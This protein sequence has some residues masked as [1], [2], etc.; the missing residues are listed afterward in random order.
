MKFLILTQYFHPEIGAAQVRLAA[1]AKELKQLGHDVEIVTAMPNYPQGHIFSTYQ[2]RFY[3]QEQWEGITI[4]RVWLY[5]ATG[6]GIKRLLN[7]LSF[8]LTAFWGLKKAR[9]PDYLFVESPPLFLGITGYLAAKWWKIPFIFNVADLWPDSVSALGLMKQGFILRQFER[10]ERWLY[11]K[12]TYVNV[13]AEGARQIMLDVKKVPTHKVLFLPNGADTA[14]F[15][16]YS[17]DPVLYQRFNLPQKP[18]ILYAG[19]HG[20]AHGMEVI[21]QAAK[22]VA[23]LELLFLFVGGGSDKPRIQQLA[24]EMQL[25]NVKFLPPQSPETVAKL[26]GLSIAGI[27]SFRNVELLDNTRAAKN[28]AV[29]A[30]GKPLIY[31]GGGEGARLI[32]DNQTGLVTPP[33]DANTLAS[34][35]KTIIKQPDYAKKLGRNGRHFIE[36]Q[37][38]W[39]QIITNWL[40]SLIKK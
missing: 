30:C 35:I 33:E 18:I 15:K 40:S 39:H 17:P 38:T 22:L 26:Y 27:S 11:R 10:L 1:I 37:L 2:N 28:L 23:D 20:Y 7:Y 3:L 8:M 13:V 4:H 16:P 21:L 6:A 36:T 34:S 5:A 24:T 14:I 29:M 32:I 19:T 31:S 12:A 9:K 25:N